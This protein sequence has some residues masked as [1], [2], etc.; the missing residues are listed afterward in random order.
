MKVLVL[1]SNGLVGSSVKRIFESDNFFTEVH[2]SNRK[3][4]NLF[5][6]DQTKELIEN[7]NSQVS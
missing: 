2:S 1:G 4:T 6:L 5:L 3:D 7:V